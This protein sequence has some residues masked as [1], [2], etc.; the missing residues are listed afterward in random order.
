MVRSLPWIELMLQTPESRIRMIL[1]RLQAD[2]ARL[3]EGQRHLQVR[4]T[5]V[6]ER[7]AGVAGR[8]ASLQGDLAAHR[9]SIDRL[10]DRFARIG[11][12]PELSGT[13]AASLLV[14]AYEPREIT[15]SLQRHATAG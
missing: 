5:S 12:R 9:R 8:L 15:R 4:L 10:E 14:R 2:T 3:T 1:R 6:E 11:R 7:L 13:A